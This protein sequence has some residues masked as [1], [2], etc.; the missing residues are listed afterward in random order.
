MLIRDWEKV[1]PITEFE[2]AHKGLQESFFV[3]KTPLNNKEDS[4]TPSKL[5]NYGIT[6]VIDLTNTQ[7][8]YSPAQLVGITHTKI[9]MN[10][11][12]GPPSWGEV[13]DALVAVQSSLDARGK[14]FIHCTHG[15]NRS[16][17]VAVALMVLRYNMPVK[18]A[19]NMF[20]TKR[21]DGLNKPSYVQNLLDKFDHL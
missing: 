2:M 16:G 4:W 15:H 21:H 1:E 8:Y 18:D 5:G 12:F 17:Y 9:S 3:G 11:Y 6:S 10:G 14:P 13:E 19:I 20:N 7:K